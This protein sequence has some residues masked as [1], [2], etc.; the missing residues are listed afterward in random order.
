MKSGCSIAAILVLAMGFALPAYATEKKGSDR[1]GGSVVETSSITATVESIDYNTRTVTLRGP[2]GDL[3]S[4]KVGEEAK[5]F[6]Q[7]KK[8]DKVTFDYYESVA[9]DIQKSAGEPK[10]EETQTVTRAK[11]GER[12]GGTIETTGHMTA[13]VED[14]DYQSRMITLKLPQGDTMHLKVGDQ[15]K[16]FNEIKKGD[17]IVVRYTQAVAISV[18]TP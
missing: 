1:P 9:V 5:N 3:V 16:R 8:G 2:N 4:L 7:V 18:H 10:A 15:V 6:N 12:P 13:R 17:E 14:I 11:P